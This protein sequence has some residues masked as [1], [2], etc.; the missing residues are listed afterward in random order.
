M[1]AELR[2]HAHRDGLT[3]VEFEVNDMNGFVRGTV[4]GWKTV[5]GRAATYEVHL[6]TDDISIIGIT[7]GGMSTDYPQPGIYEFLSS[8]RH[9]ATEAR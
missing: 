9:L 1:I 2:K 7:A 4:R 6:L 5:S 3:D 8:V